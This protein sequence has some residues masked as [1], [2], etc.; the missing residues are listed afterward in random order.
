VELAKMNGHRSAVKLLLAAGAVWPQADRVMSNVEAVSEEAPVA[1][2]GAA[3]PAVRDSWSSALYLRDEQEKPL[4]DARRTAKRIDPALRAP[5]EARETAAGEV[6]LDTDVSVA[7]TGRLSANKLRKSRQGLSTDDMTPS[8]SVELARNLDLRTQVAKPDKRPSDRQILLFFYQQNLP[9]LALEDKCNAV[10]RRFKAQALKGGSPKQW[11]RLMYSQLEGKYGVSPVDLWKRSHQVVATA[12]QQT[13]VSVDLPVRASVGLESELESA[14]EPEPEPEPEPTLVAPGSDPEPTQLRLAMLAQMADYEGC[15][16]LIHRLA[17]GSKS[18][19]QPVAW[20]VNDRLPTKGGTTPL[21]WAASST[22]AAKVVGLLI[23]NGATSNA[24]AD[25]GTSPLELAATTQIAQLLLDAGADPTMVG[26]TAVERGLSMARLYRAVAAMGAEVTAQTPQTP[27]ADATELEEPPSAEDDEL[28][29]KQMTEQLA[30]GNLDFDAFSNASSLPTLLKL[31]SKVPGAAG[32]ASTRIQN[33]AAAADDLEPDAASAIATQALQMLGSVVTTAGDEDATEPDEQPSADDDALWREQMSTQMADGNLDFDIFSDASSLPTLRRLLAIPSARAEAAKRIQGIAA[34]KMVEKAKISLAILDVIRVLAQHQPLVRASFWRQSLAD[35]LLNFAHQ[36]VQASK[37]ATVAAVG[38]ERADKVAKSTM[39]VL[40]SVV[41]TLATLHTAERGRTE[42]CGGEAPSEWALRLL[43]LRLQWVRRV[44][45][46][47]P[48]P[49]SAEAAA[50]GPNIIAEAC[51]CKERWTAA[52]EG[53][54]AEL[55]RLE[56][57][58]DTAPEGE[59]PT[60]TQKL[61]YMGYTPGEARQLCY[62]SYN[63]FSKEAKGLAEPA[64]ALEEYILSWLGD[65]GCGLGPAAVQQL[66][67]ALCAHPPQHLGCTCAATDCACAAATIGP[68]PPIHGLVYKRRPGAGDRTLADARRWH[69]KMGREMRKVLADRTAGPNRKQQARELAEAAREALAAEEAAASERD[70]VAG[71][72]R[73]DHHYLCAAAWRRLPPDEQRGFAVQ[74]TPDVQVAVRQLLADDRPSANVPA[75]RAAWLWDM[76]GAGGDGGVDHAL[77]V[78]PAVR[79]HIV[80]WR[81][82]QLAAVE[83]WRA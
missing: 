41:A 18:G 25:D 39:H 73:A 69:E 46:G 15:L 75:E 66:L 12:V 26:K 36:N 35:T 3:E 51:D 5:A 16:I 65:N 23:E 49:D 58:P 79:R 9:E 37:G 67:D 81:E 50:G 1:H 63:R 74:A 20:S 64:Q 83:A 60:E 82:A 56:D 34:D 76:E 22:R 27:D 4:P 52:V 61:L 31:A 40:Q 48:P 29:T 28:W 11:R 10:I 6:W 68:S 54:A 57:E 47:L 62:R 59:Q 72:A 24:R 2:D 33:I 13:V 78:I 32:E 42:A 44:V 7:V 53:A 43:P 30:E 55:K 71:G 21:H 8:L 38:R 19:E 77:P 17:K 80:A 14:P 45:L 70:S